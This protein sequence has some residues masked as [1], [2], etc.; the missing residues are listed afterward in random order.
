MFWGQ[1]YDFYE[2]N[3]YFLSYEK[4]VLNHKIF[5]YTL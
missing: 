4:Y 2:L 1:E 3:I 5:F